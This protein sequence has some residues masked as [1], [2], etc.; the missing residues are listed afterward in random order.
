MFK[1]LSNL[2]SDKVCQPVEM[3]VLRNE[4]WGPSLAHYVDE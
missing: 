3:K 1:A 4:L 2:Q